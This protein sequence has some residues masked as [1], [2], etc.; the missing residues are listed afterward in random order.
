MSD[1]IARKLG[2]GTTVTNLVL[3]HRVLSRENIQQLKAVLRRN[4]ALES[5][6]L[7]S[8]TLGSA[9]LAEIAPVLYRNTSIKSLDLTN[10]GLYDIESAK[11]LREL[12]RCN[13]TITSLCIDHN[14]FGRNAAAVRSIAD[15]VRRN[16]TLHQL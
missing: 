1:S 13:K 8:T 7:T 9:G 12:I 10:N 2:L 4:T 11:L 5:L 15:G 16:T 6:D 14:A 3:R